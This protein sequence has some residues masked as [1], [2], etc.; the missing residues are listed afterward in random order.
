MFIL[1][2][3]HTVSSKACYTPQ[4]DSWFDSS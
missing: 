2:L 1:I 4:Y 3:A